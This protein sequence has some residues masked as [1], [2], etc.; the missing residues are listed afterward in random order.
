MIV[1]IFPAGPPQE[2]RWCVSWRSATMAAPAYEYFD[3]EDQAITRAGHLRSAGLQYRGCNC[4]VLEIADR[5]GQL[6]WTCPK[7]G[8]GLFDNKGKS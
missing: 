8:G 5:E 6:P 7:H 1:S 4:N 2:G 3:D